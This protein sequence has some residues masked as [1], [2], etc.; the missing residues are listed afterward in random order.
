VVAHSVLSTV[1]W[2]WQPA[3]GRDARNRAGVRR[4]FLTAGA[5]AGVGTLLTVVASSSS[6]EYRL[7]WSTGAVVTLSYAAWTIVAVSVT[8]QFALAVEE[9]SRSQGDHGTIP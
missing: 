5:S 7:L 4:A 2:A 3:I 9:A 8:A 6:G 1:R